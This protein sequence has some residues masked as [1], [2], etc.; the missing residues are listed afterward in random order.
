MGEGEEMMKLEEQVVSLDLAKAL[1]EAGYL[2]QGLWWWVLNKD[3][4]Y[5]LWSYRK[6][7]VP[8][9]VTAIVAPTAAEILEDLPHIIEKIFILRI[10]KNENGYFLDYFNAYTDKPYSMAGYSNSSGRTLS[11]ALALMWLYLKKEGLI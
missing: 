6:L 3:N 10:W 7:T 2:Q 4:E 11:N 5:D 8:K 9:K 1:K